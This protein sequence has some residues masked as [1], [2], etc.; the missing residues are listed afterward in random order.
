MRA[1]PG[2]PAVRRAAAP[3]ETARAPPSRRRSPPRT[4]YDVV[5]FP[6]IDWD[7]RFQRP[8]QLDGALRAAGHRVFY[9]AQTLPRTS[10]PPSRSGKKRENVWEVSLRRP[11]R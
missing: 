2:P 6:I 9:V 4:V 11:G 10:G 8:Q 5:C 7:F 1:G 3:A